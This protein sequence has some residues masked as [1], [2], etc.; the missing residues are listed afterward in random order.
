MRR[1]F[2]L[3]FLVINYLSSRSGGG[4]TFVTFVVLSDAI[5]S[6]VMRGVIMSRYLSVRS[7]VVAAIDLPSHVDHALAMRG[8]TRHIC[9]IVK[10]PFNFERT[11]YEC[12]TRLGAT[13][14]W[15]TLD[16]PSQLDEVVAHASVVDA[17]LVANTYVRDA[18]LRR[19]A[20]AV[21]I[22]P[23]HHTNFKHVHNECR[24]DEP[25]RVAA[26]IGSPDNALREEQLA[27]LTSALWTQQAIRFRVITSRDPSKN[28]SQDRYHE[29]LD[30]VD[31]AV[32]WPNRHDEFTLKYRP[33]TRLVHWWSHGVP[34]VYYPTPSYREAATPAIASLCAARTLDALLARIRH[35]STTPALRCRLAADVL[36]RSEA[37]NASAIAARY[38]SLLLQ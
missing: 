3:F 16:L 25:I 30:D 26:F 37:Y 7:A 22:L 6:T 2:I 27:F 5:G 21:H 20:R 10:Y 34:V 32:I 12:R 13:L 4:S 15:D 29:H 23:H 19:G 1:H 9:V 17:W 33:V 28:A 8:N 38:A 31:V 18:F 11:A 24:R 36:R 35:L 14:M